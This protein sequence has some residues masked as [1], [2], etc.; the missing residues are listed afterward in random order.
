MGFKKKILIACDSSRT[1]L[2]FRGNLIEEL[3]A[4]H[5]VHVFTP[6]VEQQ[7]VRDTLQRLGVHTVENGLNGSN[8]SLLSDVRYI[9]DLYTVIRKLKPDVFF[10][11]TLKP[12]IYGS[13][14]ASFCKVGLITPML[15]GLGYNFADKR[16]KNALVKTITRRLLKLSLNSSISKKRLILQNKDDYQTL[17]QAGVIS[18][19]NS[20]H[21]V[22]GSGVDLKFYNY[23][24]P[25]TA[26]VSFL[27][28][29]R[30]INA[31]GINEYYQAA[32]MLKPK[33]GNVQFRLIG[34]Y[35]DNI[36]SI[37]PSLFDEIKSGK[38]IDYLG[39]VDDVRPYIKQASIVV[40]PSYYGEG[41]PRCILEGMAMGRAVITSD[42]VGCRETV[43]SR[44]GQ[45]NGFLVPVKDVPG[46]ASR[47]QHFITNKHDI[48][49]FGLNGRKYAFEKFDVQKVNRHMLQIMDIS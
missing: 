25:E 39:L 42:S 1:L 8:V 30:L 36:D 2:A 27:M 17:L 40:L 44:A 49:L 12:V 3:A 21:V 47:M 34:S 14:V 10:P 48:T 4:G 43:N 33:F 35:D 13:L 28:I 20:V 19:R 29:A 31:K 22:N 46:L 45:T 18:R 7:H 9:L 23:S 32:K 38:V 26:T 5:E 15:T 37:E 11:Y 24:P 16:S 6:K 41:V